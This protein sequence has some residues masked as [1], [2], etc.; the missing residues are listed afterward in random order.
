MAN[1]PISYLA[2][3]AI[4]GAALLCGCGQS[5]QPLDKVVFSA[6]P[7][8]QIELNAPTFKQ[9]PDEDLK[10]LL[11]YLGANEKA[12]LE[13]KQ[14]SDIAGKPLA[15]VMQEANTWRVGMM[16]FLEKSKEISAQLGSMIII[17]P[18]LKAIE[19]NGSAAGK[20][21][22]LRISYQLNNKSE[23][24]ITGVA[25]TIKYYWQD[26][27]IAAT[28]PLSFEGRIG[29]GEVVNLFGHEPIIVGARATKE[30]IAFARAPL[31]EFRFEVITQAIRLENGEILSV[32]LL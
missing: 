20:S 3:A 29:S 30:M 5:I 19:D 6:D 22:L 2:A 25:G 28:I 17:S 26:G 31:N 12:I 8:K 21:Q 7:L 4:I 15:Q 10:T 1:R 9:I 14:H 16:A 24:T 32:P 13:Q 27:R 18:A 23:R 11:A